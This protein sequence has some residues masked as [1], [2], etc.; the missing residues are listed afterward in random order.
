MEINVAAQK[1]L[2]SLSVIDGLN[3]GTINTLA[4][5][6]AEMYGS[7]GKL[8]LSEVRFQ[9]F[10]KHFGPEGIDASSLPPCETELKCQLERANFVE[11]MWHDDANR[12]TINKLQTG[13]WRLDNGRCSPIWFTGAQMPPTLTPGIEDEDSD[14]TDSDTDVRCSVLEYDDSE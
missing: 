8:S 14:G 12:S 5:F 9:A 11:V 2:A 1:A 4:L 3:E 6:I 13:G 7:R 10:I